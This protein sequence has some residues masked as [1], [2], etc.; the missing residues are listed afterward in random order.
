MLKIVADLHLHT[1]ASGHA[2]ST[3]CEYAEEAHKK[4][5]EMI[6]MTDHGPGMP[7]G[8][9]Y[10]HFANL[11]S[12]PDVISGVRILKGIEANI[13]DFDGKLDIE[14]TWLKP[15]DIVI[16]SFHLHLGHDGG[17]VDQNTETI[18]KVMKNPYVD[19]IGHPVN[20][21]FPMHIKEMVA[22]A[23]AAGKVLEI[24]NSS[25]TGLTRLGS[26]E[27]CT[28]II[29]EAKRQKAYIV[30]NSDSHIKH[31]IGNVEIA[32][33]ILN[34]EN[35]PEELIVNATS[36]RIEKLILCRKQK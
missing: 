35:F 30:V 7:G 15:L 18:L 4:G 33:D 27:P 11:N 32:L 13:M 12:V 3:I 31:H 28:E 36:G 6:A 19:I 10:Y 2:Y 21:A 8:P 1:V 14:D 24:N 20:P 9:H 29:R 26:V 25:F 22:G 5:L 16:A 17:T 23:K 34:K